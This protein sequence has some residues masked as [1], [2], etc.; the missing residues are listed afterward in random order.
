MAGDTSLALNTLAGAQAAVTSYVTSAT[1]SLSVAGDVG[2]RPAVNIVAQYLAA[3]QS[4]NVVAGGTTDSTTAMA[5]A[6][7][8]QAAAY[9]AYTMAQSL[10]AVGDVDFWSTPTI[11]TSV[12]VVGTIAGVVWAVRRKGA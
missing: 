3:A 12:L 4:E 11:V 8:A 10:A 9:S 2:N 1:S 6:T 5:A 7:A